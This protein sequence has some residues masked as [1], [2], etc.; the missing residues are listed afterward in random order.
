[1]EEFRVGLVFH[2]S[3]NRRFYGVPLHKP[4]GHVISRHRPLILLLKAQA[5]LKTRF[6]NTHPGAKSTSF[7]ELFRWRGT[8]VT[9]SIPCK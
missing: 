9:T 1:M 7:L 3:S 8:M 2:P 4:Q 5:Q 6:L